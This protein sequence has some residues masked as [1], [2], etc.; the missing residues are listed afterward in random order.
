MYLI[1]SQIKKTNIN[2]ARIL[3]E[4]KRTQELEIY[5]L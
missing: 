3:I 5:S 2:I 1:F 4:N